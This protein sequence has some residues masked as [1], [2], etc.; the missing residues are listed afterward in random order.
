MSLVTESE[1][2][3]LEFL[4]KRD[5]DIAALEFAQRVYRQYRTMILTREGMCKDTKLRR[6]MI[7]S[8]AC[9]REFIYGI[10]K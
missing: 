1:K 7:E 6:N 5:G 8:C 4:C 9:L 10:C 2:H 3:R